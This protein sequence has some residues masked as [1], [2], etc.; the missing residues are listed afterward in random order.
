MTLGCI[1]RTP[2]DAAAWPGVSSW[3]RGARAHARSDASEV[4]RRRGTFVLT[5]DPMRAPSNGAADERGVRRHRH[6][7]EMPWESFGMQ[8]A[9]GRTARGYARIGRLVRRRRERIGLSQRQLQRLSG[10][11]QSVISRLETG[12]LRGLRF[13][14]LA[15]LVDALGGIGDADPLPAW[16]TRYMP[17]S[18]DGHDPIAQAGA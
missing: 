3:L 16:A 4:H 5:A 2:V 13:S 18:R 9:D 15:R 14:R 6:H 12:Q 7:R 8:D 10:I 1:A 11:D 17:P